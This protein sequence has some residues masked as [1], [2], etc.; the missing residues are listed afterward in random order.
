MSRRRQA[1]EL[2]LQFLYG[3]DLNRKEL[4]EASADF[5]KGKNLPADVRRFAGE[6]IDGTVAH[7]DQIDRVIADH[8]RNW[9][10]SRLA[11]VDK[12]ILRLA[13]YE[14]YYRDDIPPLVTINEAVEIAK[15][16]ST[17]QSGHFVNGIL[18]KV[19]EEIEKNER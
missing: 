19:R 5:W 17:D 3:Y 11:L 14:L 1:R 7:L 8:A 2:A 12:Q 10:L 13:L 16:F 18:D 9:K 15:K 4:T 6:L